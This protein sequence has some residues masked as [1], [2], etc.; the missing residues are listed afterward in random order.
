M[1][2]VVY[3]VAVGRGSRHAF[4][5]DL[6]RFTGGRLFSIDST[7]DL[8]GTFVRVLDEFRHRYLVS[9]S[10]RGVA[11]AGW[12]RLD[13]RYG[14]AA[15]PCKRAADIRWVRRRG[16]VRLQLA[17]FPGRPACRRSLDCRCC[18][19]CSWPSACRC[20]ASPLRTRPARV[21]QRAGDLTRSLGDRG[22]LGR[23]HL[24]RA[25]SGRRRA[26][27]GRRMKP[28]SR[29]PI[30]SPDGTQLAFVSDRTGGGDIYILTLASGALEAADLRRR[31]RPARRLV[32]RRRVDLL[33][34]RPAATSPA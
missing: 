25:R 15:S 2:P 22:R 26:P 1:D 18:P 31:A 28:P 9:Y 29:R 33:L 19:C 8:R 24:D 4:L 34:D 11:A 20:A 27:A 10:P 23:R 30:Y 12:H 7:K 3:A 6:T 14:A 5:E 21:V 32:A 13:V 17:A 16:D